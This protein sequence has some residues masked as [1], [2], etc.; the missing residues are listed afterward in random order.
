LSEILALVLSTAMATGMALIAPIFLE[1]KRQAEAALDELTRRR[2]AEEKLREQHSTLRS[3]INSADARIFSVDRELRYTAFNQKHADTMKQLYGAQIEL[4][5][6]IGDYMTVAEDRDI[7]TR[8]LLRTLAGEV[9]VGEAYSGEEPRQRRYLRVAHSPIRTE[10]GEVI[11]VAV[12]AQDITERVRAE[13]EIRTLNRE[14]DQRVRDRTAE[15]NA[16][17][18]E[19]E[20]FAYSVSHDLRAPLRHID[21]FLELLKKS[22]GP[23]LEPGEQQHLHRIEESSRRMGA[24]VDDLL[25]FSRMGRGEVSS[26]AVDLGALVREV[27]QDCEPELRDRR[28]RWS[29]GDLGRV[30]G[31]R[32][33][34][35]VVLA[36]LISNALKF[37]RPREQVQVEIGRE[38]RDG[39][40]VVFVRDNGVGFDMKYA[41]KLFG[42][43]QRLHRA[44]EFEGTGVGL[45]TVQRVVRRHGGRTWAEGALGQG[46]TF[47][48]ALPTGGTTLD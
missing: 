33:M 11:G 3:I 4:G 42:V 13:E 15:L 40:A 26:A 5:H 19:L 10:T 28:V 29:V 38:D 9:H 24:L 18:Q 32:A 20:A 34:L 43:F 17:N 8:N 1:R 16:A 45:A 21:G 47:Y 35:R 37:S 23:R 39:E 14:L 22:L 7:A 48:F 25:A 31:D 36:N 44:E 46:A 27:I 12:L 41:G 6:R 2:A 30:T